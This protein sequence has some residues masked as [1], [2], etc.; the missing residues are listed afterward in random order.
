MT[1]S[2][3]RGSL[4]YVLI[5]VTAAALL[6]LCVVLVTCA[7]TG[8]DATAGRSARTGGQAGAGGQ[9]RPG[10]PGFVARS[11]DM[12]LLNG[13][14]FRFSGKNIF[15]GGLDDD[16]RIGLN[17][18]TPFRVDSALQTVVD[19]GETVIRCQTCGISTGTPFS[20]EPRLGA[21]SQRALRRID[22]FIAR[23]QRYGLKVVI[24]L[25]DNYGYY[26]GSYCDYTSWLRLIPPSDCPSA[27][28]VSA[29]YDNQKAV[30][31]F[32]KYIGVLLNHVNRYTGVRN[33]DNPAIMA[34]ETGNE[35]PY[36]V[37]GRAELSRWTAKISAFI[38]S[39]DNSQLIMDGALYQEPDD[40]ELP[41]VDIIDTH[42]YPLSTQNLSKDADL[43]EAADKP[44]V[45]GEYA[46]NDTSQLEAFLT[47]IQQTPDSA[48]DIYWDLQPQN[49]LF[50]YVEHYDGYQL[51]YPGDNSD[52]SDDTG[53]PL[54]ARSS[55]ASA[56]ASLR[57]HA[58]AMSATPVPASPVPPAP[59]MTNVERVVSATAGSGNLLEWRGSPGAASYVVQR[60]TAS[61]GGPWTTVATVDA[62]VLETPYLDSRGGAGPHLWY[63]GAAVN[64]A[65]GRG[66]ASAS[67][68]VIDKTLDDNL[69]SFSVMQS[70]A[71]GVRIDRGNAWQY[72]GDPSR[73]SFPAGSE[74]T[75]AW[76]VPGG[77]DTFEAMAYY[78]SINDM[79]FTF[80]V[81]NNDRTWQ[82]VPTSDVQAVQIEGSELGDRIAF[83]YT[84]D[85]VQ[86]VLPNADYVRIVRH[87]GGRQAAEIGEVRITY[88]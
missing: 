38:R 63:R 15:W 67:F 68:R 27:A 30:A 57:A 5:C 33:K 20:V 39:Q 53:D 88:P 61:A 4:K 62:G 37:G 6:M 42:F 76:G 47:D 59:A 82:G 26:L 52:V 29:F 51:H 41:D 17:Y 78:G 71:Q 12:L 46:W 55:D 28:A 7:R 35:M 64:A 79:H 58:F 73:A 45:V 2:D 34:W 44:M 21:F 72:G 83:I 11:G 80:Q 86:Q 24:P 32:E 19:M 48:G 8:G 16:E 43:A 69:D 22:Y 23:A 56:V 85:D 54:I 75:A 81:S 9:A 60:A 40:L 1:C 50:G 14:Q 3:P 87:R 65:G 70:R 31:A 36:G 13:R 66:A 74:T 84:L 77:I 18:P 49:D 10:R 25:T